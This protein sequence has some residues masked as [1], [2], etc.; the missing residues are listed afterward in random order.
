MDSREF[1]IAA[2]I[3]EEDEEEF[4]WNRKTDWINSPS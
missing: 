4:L 3:E 2:V 1:L